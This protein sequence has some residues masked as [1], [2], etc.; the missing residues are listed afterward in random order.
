MYLNADAARLFRD[1]VAGFIRDTD[2]L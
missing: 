2:R 1:S